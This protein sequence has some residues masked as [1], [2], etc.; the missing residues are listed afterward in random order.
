MI[1]EASSHANLIKKEKGAREGEIEGGRGQPSLCSL[2]ILF[3]LFLVPFPLSL[4]IF[5]NLF[6]LSE[7]VKCFKLVKVFC[8]SSGCV[9]RWWGGVCVSVW[10]CVRV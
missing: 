10:A 1:N 8:F 2:C 9:R 7:Q 4:S 3:L 6:S 5:P